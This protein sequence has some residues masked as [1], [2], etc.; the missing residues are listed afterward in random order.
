MSSTLPKA[1]ICDIDKTLA[2]LNGRDPYDASTCMEDTPNE[3]VVLIT[4]LCYRHG[5]Q[6]ILVTGREEQYREMTQAWLFQHL[7]PYDALF[8]KQD[9]DR[10]PQ[11]VFKQEV[12]ERHIK[13]SFCV[14]FVLEDRE[15]VA[16]MYRGLG[17]T[18]LQVAEGD[19]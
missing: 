2:L 6:V 9:G 4:R 14:Q 7:I 5:L 16:M 12:Y 10:R 3:P 19:Y 13:E 1:V 17:L 11:T 8:M 18:V 15:R